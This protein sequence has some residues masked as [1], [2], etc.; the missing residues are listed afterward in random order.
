MSPQRGAPRAERSGDRA[1]RIDAAADARRFGTRRR[2]CEAAGIGTQRWPRAGVASVAFLLIAVTLTIAPAR[3]ALFDDDEARKRI[4]TLRGRVDQL[5]GR[6][7]ALESTVKSQG[8][9]DLLRDIEQIKADVATLRGQQEVIS[10]ELEQAQKRQRDLYLDLDGR[11]RKL[12]GAA[13]SS[14]PAGPAAAAPAG[15]EA[16]APQA[17]AAGPGSAA[18]PGTAARAPPA[19]A[20][21]GGEQRAYDAALDQFKSGSYAA[22]IGSFQAFVRAYPRSALAPSAMYWQGNAQYAQRDFRGAIAT[23][24]Q[25]IATY[26]DSQKVPDALLNIASCQGEMGDAAG[27]RRTFQD[28]V[29]RFPTSEAAGKARQRLGR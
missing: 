14:G 23:Q 5:E 7:N 21:L 6:L 13:G 20:D 12:E 15:A 19:A 3:A 26:P 9:V 17:P 1:R 16:G 24:R 28:L 2:F 25:L 11:L 22:A 4:E 29:A 27:A 18:L 8:L 10:Y